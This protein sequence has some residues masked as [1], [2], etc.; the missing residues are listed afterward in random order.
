MID[1]QQLTLQVPHKIL[2]H[3]FNAHIASGERIGIFGPNGA[4]KSTFLKSLMGLFPIASGQILLNHQPMHQQCHHIA[5]LPQEFD[6]LS[7][8]YS[9]MGFL[10]LL[11]RGNQ[12][13]LPWLRSNDRMRCEKALTDVDAMHLANKKLKKLSGGERKRIM[14][15][16]LLLDNPK[17]LLLDEPLAN[18]DPRYQSELLSLIDKLQKKLSLT[19]LITAHD[20]NPLLFLLDRVMFIGEGHAVLDTPDQVIQSDVLSHLY[21][22]PLQVVEWHHRKW[23]LSM[24]SNPVFLNFSEHCHGEHCVSV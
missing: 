3:D 21:K 23:V 1:I 4:G 20:F 17:I 18:L 19:L 7:V 22:T 24:E 9:V 11:I 15:A 8:D 16:A 13:G 12:W 5:Y 6:A 14:L 2:L 10:Q